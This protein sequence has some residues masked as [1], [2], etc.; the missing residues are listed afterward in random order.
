MKKKLNKILAIL[1]A[2]VMT[3]GILPISAVTIF[4]VADNTF[5][6]LQ[7][8]I[9]NASDG[10]TVKLDKDYT[11]LKDLDTVSIISIS[12]NITLDLNGYSI[13]GNK[14][15]NNSVINIQYNCSLT[16]TDSSEAKTGTITGGTGKPGSYSKTFG[17]GVYN[18]GTFTMN[19]GKIS[20]NTANNAGAVYNSGTFKMS[21]GEISNNSSVTNTC[22]G[23]YNTG[24]FEMS[25]G[26]ISG[27][28]TDIE[29]GGVHNT[30]TFTMTGGEITGNIAE[31]G[32]GVHNGAT[33]TMSGGTISGNKA[34]NQSG[35]VHNIGT[36]TM[37]SGEITGNIAETGGGVSNRSTFTMSGGTI[38]DNKATNR[39]GGVASYSY[40]SF[41]VG[42]SANIT[43]NKKGEAANNVFLS[44]NNFITISE[45]KPLTTG[46]CIGLNT[47]TT[48]A[49]DSPV[50]I[51]CT[52]SSDYTN[53]FS[54]DNSAY[55]VKF[56]TDHLE[57]VLPKIA[58]SP[59]V[60]LDG[61]SYGDSAKT[62]TVTGNTGN[63]AITYSY[64]VKDADDNTYNEAVPTNVGTYTVKAEIAETDDYTSGSCTTDFTIK[65]VAPSVKAPTAK[66]G[67][68]YTG[69]AQA[70]LNEGSTTDGTLCY[71]TDGKN[72][73]TDIPEKTNAGDYTV[74]YKVIGDTN[75]SDTEAYSVNVIIAE[76][77]YQVT[78]GADEK[79]TQGTF[80]DYTIKSDGPYNEFVELKIDGKSVDNTNYTVKSGS[81]IIT[82]KKAYL[83]T[84]S[85]G[86]HEVG[87]IWK[88]GV[89]KTTF[90]IVAATDN[91][92][93]DNPATGDNSNVILLFLLLGVSALGAITVIMIMA[94]RKRKTR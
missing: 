80:S 1:L 11:Y 68:V 7:E 23:V 14:D 12:K 84:L 69:S 26:K 17:G 50:T 64:K 79:L 28:K 40:G 63:G 76:A 66:T 90:T 60:S 18:N 44:Y 93:T 22:G 13:D 85:V 20:G 25:G 36:F 52:I 92:A 27:N 9:N 72:Y 30:G 54:S 41:T 94:I 31:T 62:P 32:G 42:E 59:S 75:H 3:V 38:S 15:N 19:G 58:I 49:K 86:K 82:L 24:T 57:L 6:Q 29:G 81:T 45:E 67:L 73:T 87:M 91:P 2:T 33:F 35:G 77:E 46:A 55:N 48:P 47:F 16:L 39:G 43:G 70:L 83:E 74:Y 4:A 34:T 78:V 10:G 53:Y 51:S 37:T 89:A 56:N 88:N 21:G 8:L 65:K 71:S 5:N 61:W